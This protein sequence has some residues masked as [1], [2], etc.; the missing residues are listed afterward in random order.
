V[1]LL[2]QA[3][4][5]GRSE[6][7]F[8]SWSIE[9]HGIVGNTLFV[10]VVAN[11]ALTIAR[12]ASTTELTV[13]AALGLLTFAQVGLGYVGRDELEAA[14]W[15]VPNGVLLMGLSGYQL[16]LLQTRSSARAR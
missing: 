11:L 1:L 5:A 15:H 6:V 4:L 13:A 14:A 3:V 2:V 7:L 8:G 9:V 16:A 12:R 10:L